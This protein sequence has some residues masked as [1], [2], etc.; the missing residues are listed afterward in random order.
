MG[1][2]VGTSKGMFA[3]G[4]VKV[5]GMAIGT[6]KVYSAA[7]SPTI[8][9]TD[10]CA[11][12]SN[13]A[14]NGYNYMGYGYI[15]YSYPSLSGTISITFNKQVKLS[16]II[17]ESMAVLNA[18]SEVTYEDYGTTLIIDV[19]ENTSG[20]V[21]QHIFELDSIDAEVINLYIDQPTS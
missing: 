13:L 8:T 19:N 16:T 1:L 17:D 21:F 20:D 4:T 9:A 6:Q 18:S 5:V 11:L 2:A 12:T 7:V 14:L 10:G 3:I 15:S